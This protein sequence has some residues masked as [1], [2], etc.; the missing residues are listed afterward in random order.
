MQTERLKSLSY[1]RAAVD[2]LPGQVWEE[3][4]VSAYEDVVGLPRRQV[5]I[6]L[7]E[8]F[9]LEEAAAARM[10]EFGVQTPWQAFVQNHLQHYPQM[11]DERMTGPAADQK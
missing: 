3:Q 5:A 1:G 9:N 6:S 7:L 10:A 4:V 2:L 8:W 11:L